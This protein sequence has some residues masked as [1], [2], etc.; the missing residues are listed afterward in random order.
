MSQKGS[1]NRPIYTKFKQEHN[2]ATALYA[3]NVDEGWRSWILC[4]DMYEWVAD[5]LISRLSAYPKEWPDA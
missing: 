1:S 2:P 5:E 4:C 3:I